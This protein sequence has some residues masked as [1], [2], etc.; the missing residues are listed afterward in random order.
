M[1]I[2]EKSQFQT[3][4]L[5]IFS[6][7]ARGLVPCVVMI[8]CFLCG[9]DKTNDNEDLIVSDGFRLHSSLQS[10]M[11][12]QRDSDFILWGTANK[13][14]EVKVNVSWTDEQYEGI[15]DSEGIWEVIVPVPS[16]IEGNPE[17]TIC[18]SCGAEEVTLKNLL[19]GDVW[20]L[21]GQSNMMMSLSKTEKHDVETAKA[22]YPL[23]RYFRIN[24]L[25]SN[26]PLFD[27][28]S[29]TQ[30]HK[31]EVVSP[32]NADDVSAV[33]YYFAKEIIQQTGIP[34]GL[35]NT[36]VGGMPIR[37]F[38]PKEVFEADQ[39]LEAN[40]S[41]LETGRFYNTM[42]YPIHRISCKG[43]LWYQGEADWAK[44]MYYERSQLTLM[45]TWRERFNCR[46]DA[47]FYYVQLAPYGNG[48]K[49]NYPNVFYQ[50]G[51]LE[52][53][54][55]MREVQAGIRERD[56]NTGMAVTM[57]VG[58]LDDIH[59]RRKAQV[60]E[61]L[62]RLALN[63]DYGMSDLKYL[64]PAFAGMSLEGGV[65]KLRFDNAEG[66]RTNDDKAPVHFYVSG[67]D[68]VY[69]AAD[70]QI[71]GEEVWLC[72]DLISAAESV[73]DLTV[74]YA[75]LYAAQTNLENSAGLP[76]EPFRTD[77]WETVRYDTKK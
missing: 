39:V 76:A 65:L 73:T 45:K 58:D 47:P 61:R 37:S 2:Q 62:A 42:V 75:F 43:F 30:G 68:A 17:Q 10:N 34:V 13:G 70:A 46:D 53:Y 36:S 72:S 18:V 14:V 5:K 59:P 69:S 31:W 1:Y 71:K 60:G 54:A 74:R 9:C 52:S 25:G 28:Y 64:G 38:I 27:W 15:A 24:Q 21:G 51:K 20:I 6:N 35:I 57:D 56:P 4:C 19:I 55:L 8:V 23:M 50:S 7:K 12:L 44:W 16:V 48:Q 63:K 66:L 32:S 26:K 3:E 22:D 29:F 49:W 41:D 33:G 11:V 77:D 40:Y 67:G